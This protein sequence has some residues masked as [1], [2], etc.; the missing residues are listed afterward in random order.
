MDIEAVTAFL[1]TDEGKALLNPIIDE[2]KQPLLSKRD[3][4]L[5][6]LTG[7]Q[8]RY[9][10]LEEFGDPDA[11]AAQLSELRNK[12]PTEDNKG[13]IEELERHLRSE[14]ASRDT[15][16]TQYKEKIASESVNA[17][18]Q[19]EIAKAKGVSELLTP[20]LKSRVR[21]SLG[22]DGNVKVE[23]LTKTGEVL[24]KDGN[25]ATIADLINDVKADA[26]YGRAFEATG[27][28]GS[29][30]RPSDANTGGGVILDPKDPAY[31]L[32]K[33]MAYYKRHP[34]AI[35]KK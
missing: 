2:A 31:S 22:D 29:G 23:V 11:I 32:A 14:I 6:K 3:E 7:L 17:Q 35:P 12:K 26:V 24:Y 33:A 8:G 18:L 4:L 27:A 16:L 28:S 30:T 10:S 15:A 25:P 20:V 5:S 13:N 21:S 34:G 19:G 9:K 1:A